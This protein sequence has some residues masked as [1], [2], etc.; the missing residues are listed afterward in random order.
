MTIPQDCIIP[1]FINIT[2]RT[3]LKEETINTPAN[4][5]ETG[6]RWRELAKV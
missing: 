1:F 3:G 2:A 4:F 6:E 5:S